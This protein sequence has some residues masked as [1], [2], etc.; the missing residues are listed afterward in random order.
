M[1]KCELLETPPRQ[2]GGNM[3]KVKRTPLRVRRARLIKA[4]EEKL[5]K[6]EG[7]LAI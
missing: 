3:K 7:R 6:G 2:Q 4:R 5:N 1:T